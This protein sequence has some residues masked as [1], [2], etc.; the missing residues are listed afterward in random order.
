MENEAVKI[1]NE[2]M[3]SLT[4]QVSQ[5]L[6]TGVAFLKQF[7]SPFLVAAWAVL[8]VLNVLITPLRWI[9]TLFESWQKWIDETTGVMKIFQIALLNLIKVAAGLVIFAKATGYIKSWTGSDGVI[10]G[11]TKMVKKYA[12]GIWEL[13]KA[14]L[15][16]IPIL[17]K[18]A[19]FQKAA[20]TAGEEGASA[21]SSLVKS[22]KDRMAA[23]KDAAK[24]M[25]KGKEAQEKLT[26]ATTAGAAA[27]K[28]AG[29]T[30]AASSAQMAGGAKVLDKGLSWGLV[31]KLAVLALVF[32]ALVAVIV[33]LDPAP[34]LLIAMGAA[35]IMFAIGVKI[36]S[37]AL[38]ALAAMGTIATPVLIMLAIVILAVGAAAIMI[39]HG[40]KLMA[41]GAAIGGINLLY[42]AAAMISVGLA[43]YMIAGAI[44]LLAG[45]AV[46]LVVFSASLAA[47]GLA[48]L[49]F[50]WAAAGAVAPMMAMGEAAEKMAGFAHFTKFRNDVNAMSTK[51]LTEIASSIAMIGTSMGM[52][53]MMS[54]LGIGIS[55]I[56]SQDTSKDME[57]Q[58]KNWRNEMKSKADT[59]N[60]HLSNIA[61]NT[62]SMGDFGELVNSIKALVSK[63][64]QNSQE[65]GSSLASTGEMGGGW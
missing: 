47:T 5:I 13:T 56:F 39:G 44:P 51:K 60:S 64:G 14:V 1:F 7:L 21:T 20:K 11:A 34:A 29:T 55:Q 27:Q 17:G 23:A 25:F 16:Q 19:L 24:S 48:L 57:R 37:A 22:G 30:S 6:Q 2:R 12:S 41:E 3:Q 43:I 46:A 38:A 52:L 15:R 42:L 62:S 63:I 33:L 18:W 8:W 45:A 50:S 35:M 65:R 36:L 40:I 31:A 10:G 28:A 26:A 4:K 58:E 32:A 53:G 9:I 49:F 61:E 59:G 54:K